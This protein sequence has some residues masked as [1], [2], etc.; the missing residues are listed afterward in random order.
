MRPVV[1]LQWSLICTILVLS[2]CGIWAGSSQDVPGVSIFLTGQDLGALKPCGCSGGQLGGLERRAALWQGVNPANRLIVNTGRIVPSESEQNLIKYPILLQAYQMLGYDLV[3]LTTQ[4]LEIGTLAGAVEIVEA[5]GMQP[6]ATQGEA[7][8]IDAHFSR[9][10][11]VDQQAIQVNVIAVDAL[12]FEHL[13]TLETPSV[14]LFI[15]NDANERLLENVMAQADAQDCVVYPE[16]M[17]TPK[18]LKASGPGPMVVSIG[19]RGRY[20]CQLKIT[21]S[22]ETERPE[23]AF[24]FLAVSEDLAGNQAIKSL[25]KSYQQIVA[26]SQLQETY[27]RVPLSQGSPTFQGSASCRAC[28]A[29]AYRI[30]SA[31]Q[32]AHAFDTL[33]QAGSQRD[34]ECTICHVVGMEYDAGYLTQADTP[35]LQD[36]GC[37]VC[38]GPGSEHNRSLGKI[39]TQDPQMTCLDCHTPEHSGGYAGHEQEFLE[40]IKHWKEPKPAR[41][42]KAV[43]RLR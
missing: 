40:K 23:L 8:G 11:T 22:T 41:T 16:A 31:H 35:H 29:E 1:K 33:V 42:V 38:H 4:D 17:D 24:S 34:P 25:Y 19:Q 18:C 12:Q 3:N 30:W 21:L 28:H 37:E 39:R 26:T 32:H 43:R 14:T 9:V 36:V 20:V 6:I 5:L 15:L 27:L 7:Y 2:G 13:D 10:F